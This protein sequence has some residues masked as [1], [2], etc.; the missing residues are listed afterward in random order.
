MEDDFER[1]HSCY[2]K[3]MKSSISAKELSRSSLG[4]KCFELSYFIQ[5]YGKDAQSMTSGIENQGIDT[6][7]TSSSSSIAPFQTYYAPTYT[8][9]QAQPAVMRQST[10]GRSHDPQ[11]YP[12]SLT[13]KIN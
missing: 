9:H 7:L 12:T 10:T 8:D 5:H 3:A 4:G 6:M 13:R 2:Q 11:N 1:F